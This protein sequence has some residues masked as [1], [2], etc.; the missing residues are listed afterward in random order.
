MDSINKKSNLFFN[1]MLIITMIVFVFRNT[2]LTQL[3]GTFL[4]SVNLL[5][6]F[7]CIVL[8]LLNYSK[9]VEI[10]NLNSIL[11]NN[12]IIILYFIIRLLTF[13]IKGFDFTTF[14]S[15]MVEFFLLVIFFRGINFNGNNPKKLL[16]PCMIII[17]VVCAF[18]VL[19]AFYYII[20]GNSFFVALLKS[21]T[22]NV[23]GSRFDVNP[24]DTGVLVM[25][26]CS[27]LLSF[28]EKKNIYLYLFLIVLGLYLILSGC[29]SASV[30]IIVVLISMIIYNKFKNINCNKIM[31]SMLILSFLYLMSL[32]TFT[33]VNRDT[34]VFTPFEKSWNHYSSTRY[35][36]DK[37]TILSLKDDFVL[38]FGSFEYTG[39]K[40]YEYL[41]EHFP[42]VVDVRLGAD[43]NYAN[44]YKTLNAHNG[45]LDFISGNGIIC[46]ALF[47]YF[48][49][50]KIKNIDD[51]VCKRYFLSIIYMTVVSNFENTIL[52]II[53]FMFFLIL[54]FISCMEYDNSINN[55]LIKKENF[56]YGK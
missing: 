23:L 10:F 1:I 26:V 49:I 45:F 7:L 21:L 8:F 27:F 28:I 43:A 40:R 20:I 22:F 33:M 50:N 35:M 54:L 18:F 5:C 9:T 11:K 48:I 15:I 52:N 3:D 51:K 2:L 12:I 47:L 13:V 19:R 16:Y 24:N 53:P 30:G 56:K 41:M 42:Q 14:N 55:Q 44:K 46:L 29:R 34:I 39:E 38:G 4:I 6:F 32:F 37:Y 17:T 36:L 31:L 25:F